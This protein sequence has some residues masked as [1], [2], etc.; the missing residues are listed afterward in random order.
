MKESRNRRKMNA[1]VSLCICAA[2]L[3]TFTFVPE[4]KAYAASEKTEYSSTSTKGAYYIA[5][6]EVGT[7]V[8]DTFVYD[9]ELLKGDSKTYN[10]SLATM[11]YELAEASMSSDR[12]PKTVAGY[13]NKSRN[14]KAYLEDNGFVDFETNEWYKKRMTVS[15]MGGACA[16]KKIVDSGKEYTLLVIAPRSAGYEAEWGANFIMNEGAEDTGDH[17]GFR[18]GKNIVLAFAKEYIQKHQIN[19]DIKVWLEG[20]S[21]GAGVA[22]QVGLR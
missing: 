21:R 1:F 12:E 4:M 11:T 8:R 15:S 19:G 2:M 16:H 5:G 6:H 9:D 17:A 13:T 3:F 14:L 10:R 7:D 22:N 20:Y 18:N